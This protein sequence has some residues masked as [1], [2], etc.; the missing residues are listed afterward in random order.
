[1]KLRIEDKPVLRIK[2]QREN[3]GGISVVAWEKDD[4]IPWYLIV[5]TPDGDVEAPSLLPSHLGLSIDPD[6]TLNIKK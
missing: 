6:G 2:L 4:T 1:M 3:D 5:F